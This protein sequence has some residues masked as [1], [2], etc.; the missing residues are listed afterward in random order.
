MI[1]FI[2]IDLLLVLFNL[3][4]SCLSSGEYSCIHSS[5]IKL[6]VSGSLPFFEDLVLVVSDPSLFCTCFSDLFDLSDLLLCNFCVSLGSGLVLLVEFLF[7]QWALW[8]RDISMRSL[9]ME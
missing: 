6:S 7:C 1:C 8:M 3:S 9:R 4:C 2:L 5:L